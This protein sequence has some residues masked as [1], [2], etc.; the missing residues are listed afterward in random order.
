MPAKGAYGSCRDYR[1]TQG[2]F[3]SGGQVAH[4]GAGAATALFRHRG[5]SDG[6]LG[7][8]HCREPARTREGN[9]S[10]YDEP[11]TVRHGKRCLEWRGRPRLAAGGHTRGSESSRT[12]DGKLLRWGTIDAADQRHS[13]ARVP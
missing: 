7:I 8:R 10:P 11:R 12:L 1:V 2:G 6:V 13:G 5:V 3:A 4:C 9:P